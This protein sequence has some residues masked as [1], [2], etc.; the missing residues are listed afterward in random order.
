MAVEAVTVTPVAVDRGREKACRCTA[1]AVSGARAV[2][3]GVV[4]S[5]VLAVALV[6]VGRRAAMSGRLC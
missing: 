2:A 6:V 3:P 5:E 1:D 4:L